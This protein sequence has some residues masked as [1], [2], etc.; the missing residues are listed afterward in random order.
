MSQN[1]FFP[2]Y[3]QLEKELMIPGRLNG[4]YQ[5]RKD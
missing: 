5:S 3:Q 1:L 4:R 2:I